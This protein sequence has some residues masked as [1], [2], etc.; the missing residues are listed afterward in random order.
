LLISSGA[1]M[2]TKKFE[3]TFGTLHKMGPGAIARKK[4]HQNPTTTTD[5]LYYRGFLGELSKKT[6]QGLVP[7]VYIPTDLTLPVHKTAYMNL[8]DDD[9]NDFDA[10]IPALAEDNL[11]DVNAADTSIVDDL[12]T[13]LAY[14]RIQGAGIEDEQFLPADI[15]QITPHLLTPG[16]VRL[17]F[18]LGVGVSADIITTQD[19]RAYPK[20]SGLQRWLNL[21]RSAQVRA[22]VES[23]H[24]SALYRD[25][26]H[27]PGLHPDPEA[28]FPYDPVVGRDALV[29]LLRQ[30]VP[31]SDWWSLDDFVQRVKETE[32]DFQRPGADYES[33]YIRNDD[34]EYLHGFESWDA[35]EGALL[36]FYVYGPL[37]WLG[38]V[39]VADD[40][41]R[42]TAYGRAFLEASS[43]P[44]PPEATDHINVRED[45]ILEVSRRVSRLDRFQAARFTTWEMISSDTPHHYLYKVNADG[46][47]Q[48]A[49]QGI[50]TSH[51]ATFLTRHLNGQPMPP[52]IT[53]LLDTWQT[54]SAAEVTFEEVLVLRTTS[55]DTLDRIYETPALRRYL[56]A[57][58]GPMAC[59]IR[60]DQANDLRDALG[61]SGITVES[62]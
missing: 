3:R 11:N 29:E 50:T 15:E 48:A 36:E 24:G 35:I 60:P 8:D 21:P 20:R 23:W 53:R 43:W 2:P 40:A 39:D 52:V 46:I 16:D 18:L 42:L 30:V 4:P 9:L 32:P 14:L 45:G 25:L 59:I 26:W 37:H 54:G 47:Q 55:P 1:T 33:W 44:T 5:A 10:A 12:T 41:A 56:G 13:L 58:L 19:G 22:L 6:K 27:V 51:I 34:G 28:G 38:L 17:G 57:K 62:L 7:Y 31:N 61:Q 49:A